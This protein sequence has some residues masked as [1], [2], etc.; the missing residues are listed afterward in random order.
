MTRCACGYALVNG[1]CPQCDGRRV[2]TR[3][4]DPFLPPELRAIPVNALMFI[5]PQHHQ[6]WLAGRPLLRHLEHRKK[7]D[8]DERAIFFKHRP[9]KCAMCPST[10]LLTLDHIVPQIFGG[11]SRDCNL[12]PLCQPCNRKAFLPYQPVLRLVRG[13]A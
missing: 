13:A 8:A 2:G 9:Y 1:A 5:T 4:P 12:R 10:S 7:F 3:Q 11:S 6:A